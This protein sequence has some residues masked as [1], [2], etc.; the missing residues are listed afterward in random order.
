MAAEAGRPWA[1]LGD[2]VARLGLSV[3]PEDLDGV[4]AAVLAGLRRDQNTDL[5]LHWISARNYLDD[6]AE[7]ASLPTSDRSNDGSV[8]GR[9]E[10]ALVAAPARDVV[11]R[12][13]GLATQPN[14]VATTVFTEGRYQELL[15]KSNARAQAPIETRKRRRT[16]RLAAIAVVVGLLWGVPQTAHPVLKLFSPYQVVDEGSNDERSAV[17]P[18]R[19]TAWVILLLVGAGFSAAAWR[20]QTHEANIIADLHE[21]AYQAAALRRL[22]HNRT[23]TQIEFESALMDRRDLIR[24]PS[25]SETSP[26]VQ[27]G[28]RVAIS[29]ALGLV[30]VGLEAASSFM[31]GDVLS[32]E[33]YTPDMPGIAIAACMFG[34]VLC[35]FAFAQSGSE[36][37][38]ARRSL[39]SCA[40]AP[41]KRH[42]IPRCTQQRSWR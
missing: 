36:R 40:S 32:Y 37:R 1:G 24:H 28:A 29:V 33:T 38:S 39:A 15:A 25:R 9:G 42:L 8:S 18:L 4:R 14:A 41:T 6:L 19:A 26:P 10:G 12:G 34:V 30:A 22:A 20:R 23:F 35:T 17:E 3:D 13:L 21:P 27:L 7:E 11:R 5:A 31:V 2:V 16:Y